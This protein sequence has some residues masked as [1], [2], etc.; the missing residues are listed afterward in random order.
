MTMVVTPENVK[1]LKTCAFPKSTK[2]LNA[3]PTNVSLRVNLVALT[4][5]LWLRK[6]YGATTGET[7]YSK[8]TPRCIFE[9]F[10]PRADDYK[11]F[12]F[13]GRAM[14]VQIDSEPWSLEPCDACDGTRADASL[15]S[16]PARSQPVRAA[17]ADVCD[18]SDVEADQNG[19][20]QG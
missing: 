20:N 17:Q 5:G 14:F 1:C 4:C 11:V 6:N 2:A 18:S 16:D 15:L 12:T 10:L 3:D 8:I 13:G 19:N 7:F 9:E